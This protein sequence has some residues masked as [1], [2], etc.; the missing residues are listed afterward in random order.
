MLPAT[1][2][3]GD[4]VRLKR[5]GEVGTIL[6]IPR[7]RVLRDCV[8]VTFRPASDGLTLL[9]SSLELVKEES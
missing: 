8:V 7:D 3:A 1:V 4:K 5:T 6:F 2:K 9:R